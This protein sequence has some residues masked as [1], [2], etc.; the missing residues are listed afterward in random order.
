MIALIADLASSWLQTMIK[1]NRKTWYPTYAI[2]QA[3]ACAH[4]GLLTDCY[5][6]K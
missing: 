5:G 4:R 1:W 3:D 2:A 6:L